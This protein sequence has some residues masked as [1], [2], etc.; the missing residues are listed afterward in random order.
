MPYTK[1]ILKPGITTEATQTL[2]QGTWS[3]SNLIRWRDGYLEKLLGWVRMTNDFLVGTAR[4]MHAWQDLNN[5]KYLAVGTNERLA[6]LIAGTLHDITPLRDTA[7]VAVNFSTVLG[8]ATVVIVDAAHGGATGDSVNIYVP[9]SVGGL[10][11]HGTYEMTV[12]NANTYSIEA[13][14]NAT[15]TVN[16]GGAVA[17]F[18]TSIGLPTVTVTFANHGFVVGSIFT[19]YVSTTVATLVFLG[20]YIVATVPTANTFTIVM[21]SNA[22]SSTSGGENGGNARFE[23]LIA[24]GPVSS[25]AAMGYGTGPYGIGTW[26]VGTGSADAIDPLRIWSLDN[27]A[28]DLVACYNNG[29]IYEWTPPISTTLRATLLTGDPPDYNIV[30]FVAMPQFQ[31]VSLGAEVLGVQDPLLVRWSDAGDD[32]VWT[33]SSTNQA[34]SYRLTRGSRIV[35]GFQGPLAGYIWTD[36]DFWQMQYV[37]TPAIYSFSMIASGCGL[38]GQKAACLIDRQAYWMSLQG[39]FSY[40][41]GAVQ[42]IPCSVWDNI[43]QDIDQSNIDKSIAAANSTT[44]EVTWYYASSTG[45]GEIDSY[46]KLN[47]RTSEWD[48]GELVRTA[49][50]DQNIFGTPAGVDAAGM[51]QQHEQGYND[52]DAAMTGVMGET[53]FIDI[54]E[55]LELPFIDQIIPDFKFLGTSPAVDLTLITRSNPLATPVE[56]G[57]FAVNAATKFISCRARARQ[58]AFRVEQDGESMW[59]RLGAVRLRIAPSGRQQ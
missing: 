51:I 15:A 16:N 2:A 22:G 10:I 4:S 30:I 37:G 39:F 31:L 59:F 13:A 45:T 46:V 35:G 56:H 33:A 7:N 11:I 29:P 6:V 18:A 32:T 55:G 24:P 57:P 20:E 9:V 52:D 14:S 21:G 23:Y 8:D 47:T 17:S 53:G 43:F 49:W 50:L 26:G 3:L 1:L 12:I 19:V 36:T 58:V 28:Y 42:A 5:V 25:M 44:G 41:T 48:Y 38:V 27:Y 34:G 54:A 40:G